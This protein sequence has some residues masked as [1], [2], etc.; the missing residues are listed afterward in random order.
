MLDTIAPGGQQGRDTRA[1]LSELAARTVRP[2][3]VDAPGRGRKS[4]TGG[5]L[6]CY[7]SVARLAMRS[8]SSP[9]LRTD[10]TPRTKGLVR[11]RAF[12]LVIGAL[13]LFNTRGFPQ[14]P[15]ETPS[16]TATPRPTPGFGSTA[17]PVPGGVVRVISLADVH[18]VGGNVV[19]AGGFQI[20]NGTA[21][22]ER[23]IAVRIELSESA[24]F[25]DLSLAALGQ[26]AGVTAPS[27]RADFFF[28][29]PIEI[30]P[31]A[32]VDFALTGTIASEA[33]TSATATPTPSQ[34]STPTATPTS[35]VSS[36]TGLA[37]R[38]PSEPPPPASG[39]EG[40]GGSRDGLVIVSAMIGMSAA[41]LA[42]GGR[43]RRGLV[44]CAALLAGVAF[45]GG[46]G[47]EQ[48]SEQ[49][50]AA[51]TVEVPTGPA[52]M[53]GLPASLGTVSRPQPLTFPAAAASPT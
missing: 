39:G 11:K 48:T 12:C 19:N 32:T 1:R 6:P 50:V 30:L 17:T 20:V 24:V 27:S 53:T 36:F 41:L 51:V 9:S 47:S 4:V 44:V 15:T 25:S 43:A 29:P 52:T 7:R 46:C 10:P 31:G 42:K 28:T 13:I 21:S 16:A 40:G 26:S 33:T 22:T 49:T 45:Y 37:V 35:V 14:T 5:R 34:T 8:A 2:E 3:A 38:G 23:T 18:G